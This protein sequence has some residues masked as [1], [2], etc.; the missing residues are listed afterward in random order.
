MKRIAPNIYHI[1]SGTNSR[2]LVTCLV[3]GM[4][5]SSCKKFVAVEDPPNQLTKDKVFTSDK[6]AT[7]AMLSI[8]IDI[9]ND[10]YG[11]AGSFVCFSMSSL[12]G[13]SANEMIW[14]QSNTTAPIFQEYNDHNL[15]PENIYVHTIW[16][17]GYRYI[18]RINEIIKGAPTGTNMTE[19]V[20][21]QLEGEAKFMRAFCYF[22]LVNLF[23]DV[24][25]ILDTDY[26]ENML[27]PR[28]SAAKVWEQ[29]IADLKDAK[30]LLKEAY[31]T[32]EKLRPNIH[33]AGALLARAYLY[34]GKWEDA[35]KEAN[36]IIQSNKYGTGLPALSE[37]FKKTSPEA[38][39]QLQ[40]V[41]D[42]FNT[43]EGS[44]F[45]AAPGSRP[46][47]ELTQQMLNAFE[48][49]DDRK[50]EWVGFSDPL[51]NPTWAYPSKYKAAAEP[52]KEYYVMFRLAEQYLI[53][54]EARARQGAAKLLTAKQ[55]LDVVRTR[56]GLL[57]TTATDEAAVLLAIEQERRVEFFAEFGHRWFDLKRTNK[58]EAVLKPV[59]P[60][61]TWKEGDV[62]YPIP[63]LE[64]RANPKLDQNEAY[65]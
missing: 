37:V 44:Q 27:V 9:M 39:W 7:S 61:G 3:A 65:K 6:S 53:R 25:L 16:K 8:Y 58:A 22:Y 36:D 34:L 48:A 4:L 12:A 60:P 56:A 10:Q 29:I 41:R 33:T 14:T 1:F 52:L 59:S 40:P 55:D 23:G 63:G 20:K 64:M 54:S 46:N 31:P 13:M 49:D 17:D 51:N 15:T 18:F 19:E 62:L 38:I 28:T 26:Q 43:A 24:P 50:Q 32:A 21:R 57:P 30:T 45:R 47:Y 42:N 35:E 2:L 5:L 11:N